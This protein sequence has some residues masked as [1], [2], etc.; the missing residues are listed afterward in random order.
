[1]LLI[2]SDDIGYDHMSAFGGPAKYADVRP[3]GEAGPNLHQ[4]PPDGGL[5]GI[6]RRFARRSQ[7]TCYRYGSGPGGFGRFPG[8]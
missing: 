7:R 4:L 5:R 1:M 3:A 2:M 6:A 8:L